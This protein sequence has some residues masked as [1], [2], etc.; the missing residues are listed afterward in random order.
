MGWLIK[1]RNTNP[2]FTPDV[3]ARASLLQSLVTNKRTGFQVLM[4]SII[5]GLSRSRE[6]VDLCK[7]FGFGISY[8]DIKN[9]LASLAKAEAKNRSCSSKIANKY[10][11]VVVMDND[12]FKMDILTDASETNH[13][14]NVMFVQSEDLI[15]HKVPDATAPTLINPKGLKDLA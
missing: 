2:D 8:Q 5:Y 9:L 10:P 6:L 12:N 7:K 3:Y 13:R 1:P 11:V 4:T 14:T 15:E